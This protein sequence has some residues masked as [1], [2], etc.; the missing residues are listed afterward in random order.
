MRQVGVRELRQNAS[1]VLRRVEA[2]ETVEVTD[3]GR[4]VARIIPIQPDDDPL[5]RLM[6]E[7]RVRRG[8]GNPFDIEPMEPVPGKM[9]LSEALAELRRDER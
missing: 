6:A 7:G 9:T 8:V 1:V 2:G 4:P 5:E 3:R